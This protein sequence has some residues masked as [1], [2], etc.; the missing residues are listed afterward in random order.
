MI[1]TESWR[2]TDVPD[3]NVST[4]GFHNV[5]ADRDCTTSGKRKGGGLAVYVN[6]WCNPGQVTVKDR[7]C[8]PDIELLA[9]GLHPYYLPHEFSH[10]IAVALSANPTS[11]CDVINT[12]I[13]G[14]QTAH[15]SAFIIISGDFNHVQASDQ[16]AVEL[17]AVWLGPMS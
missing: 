1:F 15:P 17:M 12:S 5:Q 4:E 6:R 8:S 2:H 16:L 3:H 9:V 10:A 14:L 11:A 13:A 7:I